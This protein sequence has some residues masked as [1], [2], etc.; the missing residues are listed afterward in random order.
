M[1]LLPIYYTGV[2]M[3]RVIGYCRVSTDRQDAERQVTEILNYCSTHSLGDPV[4]VRETASGAKERPELERVLASLKA[5]ETLAV[6]ELSRLTRGGVGS[7]FGIVEQVRKAQARLLETKSGT[8]IDSSVAGEAYVFALGLA[9]RI[10]REMISARTKSALQAR[11]ASGVKLGRPAGKSK[12]DE[13]RVEIERYRQL[14][15]NQTAI[16][17][18]LGCSRA[19]Y[20]HWLKKEASPNATT[21]LLQR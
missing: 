14:G 12:L 6:W 10:E 7:L 13:K 17:K 15:I 1:S 8:I 2:R 4:I 11:K 3:A 20:L 21:I 9:G 16:S 5:E 19:T 18:L